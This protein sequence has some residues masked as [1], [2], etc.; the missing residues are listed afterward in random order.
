MIEI[1]SL[2]DSILELI[3]IFQ[4]RRRGFKCILILDLTNRTKCPWWWGC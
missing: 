1:A 2:T 3:I 4:R